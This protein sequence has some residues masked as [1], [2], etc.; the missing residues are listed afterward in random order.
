MNRSVTLA[1]AATLS[2]STAACA[3]TR[4]LSESVVDAKNEPAARQTCFAVAAP[5]VLASHVFVPDGVQVQSQ[6]DGFAIR[7]AQ[8][9]STCVTLEAPSA[10][11]PFAPSR[12]APACPERSGEI[13]ATSDG[14]TMLASE[15]GDAESPHVLLGVLTYDIPLAPSTAHVVG[16]SRGIAWHVFQPLSVAATG[17]RSPKLV[18]LGEER[19]LLLWVEGDSQKHQ[20]RAQPVGG[21]GS[22]IGPAIDVSLPDMDV[23]GS[24]SAA[25]TPK[26]QGMV[27]F[28]AS[29]EHGF[30]LV[31]APIA[32]AAGGALQARAPFL[33]TR[34]VAHR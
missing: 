24:P 19:F 28:L 16:S 6:D 26:G 14:E 9:R 7:F 22:A 33:S 31:A 1:L 11:G 13:A 32:C 25:V 4:A 30:D 5:R 20:L 3:T 8:A 21:W 29:G 10:T 2:L 15:S 27:A 34:Q 23:I 12:K 18:S 17:E